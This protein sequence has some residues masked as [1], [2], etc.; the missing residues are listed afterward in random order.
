MSL[1][2]TP[3]LGPGQTRTG[4]CCLSLRRPPSGLV[5]LALALRPLLTSLIATEQGGRMLARV[6]LLVFCSRRR[7]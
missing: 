5:K 6:V 2:T 1:T 4:L 7:C 3:S